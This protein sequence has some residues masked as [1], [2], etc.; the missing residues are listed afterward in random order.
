M[1][2]DLP[3][4]CFHSFNSLNQH[5]TNNTRIPWQSITILLGP[6]VATIQ[7]AR[8]VNS[9]QIPA[10]AFDGSGVPAAIDR[11]RPTA[12][13]F[14]PGKNTVQLQNFIKS[15]HLFSGF[16]QK[17]ALTPNNSP[18]AALSKTF[19]F[20]S[21][22]LLCSMALASFCFMNSCSCAGRH[23]TMWRD[24]GTHT[25]ALASNFSVFGFPL[26]S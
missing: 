4:Y 22:S 10:S 18:A 14:S 13:P 8:K 15:Q 2:F 6:T 9:Q 7:I 17:F 11:P 21:N 25:M 1:I 23:S 16:F 24:N 19:F 5:P 3:T 26:D 12:L 20:W